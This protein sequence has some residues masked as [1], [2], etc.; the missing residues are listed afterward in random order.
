MLALLAFLNSAALGYWY[1]TTFTTVDTHR[2]EVLQLPIPNVNVRTS[3]ELRSRMRCEAEVL[4]TSGN[5]SELLA[6]VAE[7]LSGATE[8]ADVVHDILAFLATQMIT[9]NRAKQ[10]EIAGFLTWL[11]G[12][13]GAKVDDLTNKTKLSAYHEHDY[14]TIYAVLKSNKR[15]LTVDPLTRGFTEHL[16]AEYDCSTTKL[17]PLLAKIESTDR[18]IDQIVYQLYGLTDEE[19]ALVEGGAD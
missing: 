4:Y 17:R 7:Q 11:E 6:L 18:L 5:G 13:M 9:M 1:R 12:H 2:N 8:R 14:E 19:I 15:R 10:N 3:R 16:R